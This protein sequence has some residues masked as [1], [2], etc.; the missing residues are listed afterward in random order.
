MATSLRTTELF[1]TLVVVGK[2]PDITSANVRSAD[3]SMSTTQTIEMSIEVDDPGWAYFNKWNLQLDTRV[4]YQDLAL[5]IASIETNEG[6]GQ[7]GFTIRARPHYV[8]RLKRRRGTMVLK[9]VSPSDFV[10]SECRAIGAKYVVQPSSKRSSV[11]RDTPPKG[12]KSGDDYSSWSTFTRLASE[13]GFLCFE[14]GGTVYFGRPSWFAKRMPK[15]KVRWGGHDDKI[16]AVKIPVCSRS[17]DDDGRATINVEV[18]AER[19]REFRPGYLLS[20]SGV[21]RFS[22]TYFITNVDFP[23]AGLEG[24]VTITAET[25]H[26]PKPQGAL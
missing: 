10:A 13:V 9:K 16:D 11:A 21:P 20:L 17:L 12:T 24:T 19:S 4:N 15:I 2:T 1:S 25:I 23:L 14:V 5:T 26:D 8:R 6:D 18:P 7:G 3:M 22:G